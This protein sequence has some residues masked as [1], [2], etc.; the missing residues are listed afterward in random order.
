MANQA[1]AICNRCIL[2]HQQSL[3]LHHYYSHHYIILTY[4]L[5]LFDYNIKV[6][7]SDELVLIP[8]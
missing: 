7:L 8:L 3:F 6:T 2:H 4:F 1:S 5:S